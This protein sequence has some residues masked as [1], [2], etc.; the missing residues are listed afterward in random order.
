MTMI[1]P[2]AAESLHWYWPDGR[3]AYEVPGA[4]GQPVNPDIRHARKLGL[5]P[6]VT[7]ILRVLAAPALERWKREQ[8]AL[9]ALTLP[10]LADETDAAFLKRLDADAQAWTRQRADDGTALHAAIEQ[11]ARGEAFD[12]R[13]APH[14]A[15]VKE[16]LSKL[17]PSFVGDFKSKD[18]FEGKDRARLF[19]DEHVMQLAAYRR[20][21]PTELPC[22][23]TFAQAFA[24]PDGYGGR[25]DVLR[26]QIEP[27]TPLVSIMIAIEP[28][29]IEVKVWTTDEARRGLALFQCALQLWKLKNRVGDLPVAPTR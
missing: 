20:G 4:K 18:T 3:P 23:I 24:H 22:P 10:R 25:I 29:D 11:E 6:S 17:P 16:A 13:F 12:P 28:A 1:L 26:G 9:A 21:F 15:R 8:Y 7:T 2:H 27:D 14:V 19:Y 5:V